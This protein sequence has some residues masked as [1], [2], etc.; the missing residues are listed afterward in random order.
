LISSETVI[1]FGLLI[2]QIELSCRKQ[3]TS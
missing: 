2:D 3:Y 1:I